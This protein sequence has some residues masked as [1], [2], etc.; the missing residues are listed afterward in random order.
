[1]W[2]CVR[3]CVCVF[4]IGIVRA[5]RLTSEKTPACSGETTR[6]RVPKCRDPWTQVPQISLC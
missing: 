1:M 5:N 2:E 4:F 6:K 3:M